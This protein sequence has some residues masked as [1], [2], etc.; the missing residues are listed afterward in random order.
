MYFL[1]KD[2]DLLEKYDNIWDKGSVDI[3]R[4]IW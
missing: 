4:R 1:I 2:D 3:K